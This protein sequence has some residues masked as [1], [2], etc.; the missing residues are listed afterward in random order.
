MG[1]SEQPLWEVQWHPGGGGRVRRA[2]LTRRGLR[3]SIA[4]LIAVGV[5]VL[6]L[7]GILPIGLRGVFARFTVDAAKKENRALKKDREVALE[8]A[9]GMAALVRHRLLLARRLAWVAA[10]AAVLPVGPVAP[11]PGA[12]AGE[13]EVSAWLL[14]RLPQL[15]A[16]AE[17]LGGG[18]A[19]LPCPLASLPTAPPVDM[20]Q[21]VQVAPFGQ[22]TSPFTGKSESHH[23][24]TLA[25]SQRRAGRRA[26]GRQGRLRRL[27]ARAPCQRVDA[28]R[29]RRGRRPRRGGLHGATATW[30]RPPSRRDRR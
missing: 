21:A 23:G 3:R 27:G 13:A 11:P 5:L 18:P 12:D 2:V 16:L 20:R 17:R 22:L 15:D 10:P 6:G 25:A 7:L 8:A 9:L 1:L 19:G 24:V 28:L 30:A 4:G 29:D 14:A 26:R